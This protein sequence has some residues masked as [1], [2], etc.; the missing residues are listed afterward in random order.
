MTATKVCKSCKR[1]L[2]VSRFWKDHKDATGLRRTCKDCMRAYSTQWYRQ[3]KD[4]INLRRRNAV[5]GKKPERPMDH[6]ADCYCEGCGRRRAVLRNA[7]ER[8][9][10]EGRLA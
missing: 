7:E 2:P 1:T 3:N 6:G 8:I 5:A 9:K 10:R 4:L